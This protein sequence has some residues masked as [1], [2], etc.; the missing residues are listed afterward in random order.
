MLFLGR[1]TVQ[2]GALH[3]LRSAQKIV[4]INPDVRFVIAGEGYLQKDLIQECLPTSGLA[5]N[6]I[7]AGK[8]KSSKP[9]NCNAKADCF[10]VMPSVSGTVRTGGTQAITHGALSFSAKS[11]AA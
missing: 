2:K 10:G 11:G 8:V 6:V 7:F 9:R 5:N 3:F 1:P 4:T